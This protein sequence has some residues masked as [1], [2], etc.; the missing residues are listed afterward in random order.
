MEYR[1][2]IDSLGAVEILNDRLYG[3]QT[4]RSLTYF[5]I[6]NELMPFEVIEAYAYIKKAAAAT[7][8][9]LNLLSL[10]K[11]EAIA[12]AADKILNRD[13]D[14]EFPL[15]V[16]QTGSGTQTNMNVNEVIANYANVML[17]YKLGEKHPVHPNDDVNL[18]QSSNDTFPTAMHIASFKAIQEKLIPNLANFSATLQT[19]SNEFSSIIKMGRTHLMDALPITL[20]QE[21]SG[22]HQQ[23]VS[24]ITHITCCLDELSELALGATAVGTGLNAHPD[25]ST[26]AIL[27]ISDLTQL[28][29]RGAKNKFSAIASHDTLVSVHSVL[30][31]IAVTLVKIA[32]DIR[33]MASGPRC[34][35]AEI[36]LPENEPGSSIMPGK[37]NP[38]QC[39]AMTMVAAQVLGNDTAVSFAGS[40]GNFELNTYKPVIIFN[41]LQ[42][43][44]LLSDAIHNFTEYALK[45]LKPNIK[46]LEK[47]TQ[48]SLMLVTALSLHIGYDK[49]AEIA[50]HAYKNN[51]SLRDAALSLGYVTKQEYQQWVIPSKMV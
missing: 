19:K 38:T 14:A 47:Y 46:Q 30:K 2:E 33:W 16:W 3:A 40:Q 5:S 51:L 10:E 48:N 12:R 41:V 6:G 11:S 39:E 21:F 24:L 13:L 27:K 28:P 17:G 50:K 29:F 18:C 37:V 25:F 8:T 35:L 43:I 23:A 32:N 49:S 20:G 7:N 34:G 26:K 42:S 4:A 22:Y 1:T 44:R 36:I 15:H 45:G 9:E 31:N